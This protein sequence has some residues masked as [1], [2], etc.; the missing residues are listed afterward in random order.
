MG[1]I[2]GSWS[3][4]RSI[5]RKRKRNIIILCLSLVLFCSVT[6]GIRF[7]NYID[8]TAIKIIAIVVL[9]LLNGLIAY[10]SMKLMGM[11]ADIDIKNIRQ[12]LIGCILGIALSLV[13]AVIPAI[14]GVSLVGKHM[15]FSWEMLIH[16]FL[17]YMLI[18][19]P[20]EEVVFRVYLQDVFVN[21]FE[22]HKWIGVVI[23]SFLFGL[24]HLI[25]GNIF[26]V[27]FTFCI[28]LV[29]GF[30]KYKIKDCTYV[31]VAI[32]HGVYD[33]INTLVRMFIV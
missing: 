28:G 32:G 15:E 27:L 29:F 13:I 25:N 20:I 30:A 2:L 23:A 24:W 26:Q 1:N 6:F 21:L 11:K 19:G 10:I 33:F 3:D 9:N 31:S 18:I 5:F 8:I 22:K 12:Y 7:I 14:C 17:L 4:M 16:D